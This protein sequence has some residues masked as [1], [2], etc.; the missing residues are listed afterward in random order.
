MRPPTP[1]ELGA[2]LISVLGIDAK[3]FRAT[4]HFHPGSFQLK[5]RVDTH[6]DTGA[7]VKDKG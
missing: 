7:Y 5:Q 6:G 1:A 4:C 2:S 3:G